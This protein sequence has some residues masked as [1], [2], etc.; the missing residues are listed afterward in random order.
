MNLR[1]MIQG[2]WALEP[3]MLSEIQ[4]IY[5]THLR[6]DKIDLPGL[7]ARLGRPL[8]NEQQDYEV[9]S[10]G[11]AVL[12][13]SGVMAPK[14]NLFAKVSGGIST[15]V[16]ARQ[17]ESAMVDQRVKGMVVVL[18]SPG[19]NVLGVQELAQTIYEASAQK[20]LVIF[21]D[22]QILSAGY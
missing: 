14:A 18:N 2:A 8:A 11:V 19:G 15:Q 20:P 22:E 3:A 9:N 10:D 13:L 1:D 5:D 7:E 6:G 21:S 17:V 12:Q 4:A 16:A